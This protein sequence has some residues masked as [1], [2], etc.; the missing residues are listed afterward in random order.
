MSLERVNQDR[1]EAARGAGEQQVSSS[2][3]KEAR[4]AGGGRVWG[5]RR[6]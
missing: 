5:V 4:R 3:S 1:E 2:K 6:V